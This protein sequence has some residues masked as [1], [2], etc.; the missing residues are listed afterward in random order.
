ML[1]AILPLAGLLPLLSSA[2]PNVT[3]RQA[4]T[5]L[6]VDLTKRYQT[7]DGFGFSEAFQ[8]ANGIINL[9]EPKRSALID[10]L[11]N[12]T[13]GAG[14]TIVRNGIGSSPNSSQDWMNT[15]LPQSPGNPTAEPKYVWDGKDSG[16]L[17]VSQQAV[18]YGVKTF[19]ANAWS[20]PGFMKTNGRDSNGGGLCGIPG[21]SCA[22]GDWRQAYA[23]Y[24]GKLIQLYEREGVPITHLG[25]VN[26]PDLTTTYASMLMNGAQAADFTKILSP[27]LDRANLSHVAIACCEATGW[28]QQ[29]TITRDMIKGGAED[30]VDVFTGHTYNSQ[31]T[32]T[33]PT[34]QKVWQTEASDLTGRWSTAWY[35][36]QG[37]TGD[38]LTW[39]NHIYM[40]LTAGNVSAYLWWVGTQDRATNNNNNEKLVLVEATN[41]EV[42]KRLW[43]FAQY[44]RTIRPGAV[45][46]QVNAGGNSNLRVTAFENVDG[47][48][49][50]NIINMGTVA[51]P[52]SVSG[53]KAK[54]ARAWITDATRDMSET[55]VTMGDAVVGGVT[56]P[57]RGM[58]S[59]VIAQAV[60]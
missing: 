44:S 38:G 24:L 20:A 17:W 18:K 51:A 56:V 16:Q 13:T 2:A 33:L 34:K 10:L 29:I 12:E 19:Y 55:N 21:Y 28:N 11:F 6:A 46:V 59:I 50:V 48:I 53:I 58:M 3:P 45:R 36:S 37:A 30:L 7:I 31:I 1:T 26:E 23:D 49:A 22:S 47:K 9:P 15:I 43:A 32:Q 52:V 42:S 57:V 40:G 8:R 54:A 4:A 60:E 5:T 41:Y 14:F 25:F 39:A 35:T 27:T